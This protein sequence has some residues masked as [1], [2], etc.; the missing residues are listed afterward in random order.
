MA[1]FGII[2]VAL[3]RFNMSSSSSGYSDF[4]TDYDLQDLIGVGSFGR[5]YQAFCKTN[6]REC[7]V[8]AICKKPSRTQGA[9][10]IAKIYAEVAVHLK[11]RNEHILQLYNVIEDGENVYLILE[12]CQGGSLS[13][14]LKQKLTPTKLTT[15]QLRRT[16]SETNLKGRRTLFPSPPSTPEHGE[17]K[18][19]ASAF[20]HDQIRCILVQVLNGLNYLHRNKIIHRD[21][22][23]NNLLLKTKFT[24]DVQEIVI[25]IADFG[26]ALD[27]S[28]TNG[29]PFTKGHV[30]NP[31]TTSFAGGTI[32][33]T[34]GFISPE[35]WTQAQPISPASDL[36]GVGSILYS[37][38]TGFTPRGDIDLSDMSPWPADLISN[39]LDPNPQNRLSIDAV[40]SHPYIVGPLSTKRL[41]PIK[42]ESK[43]LIFSIDEDSN[44]IVD[45]GKSKG[46]I[47]INRN[48]N[49][50]VFMN[51]KSM[52]SFSFDGLP[53][54]HW[55]KYL[56]AHRFVKMVKDKTP[57]VILY[58]DSSFK[59]S[60]IDFKGNR[61][62]I[63]KCTL[64][65]SGQF[66]AA[67]QDKL[68][69]EVKKVIFTARLE[70]D[71]CVLYA[72]LK[73]LKEHCLQV[74]TQLDALVNKTGV[75]C[76]PMTMG[77]RSGQKTKSDQKFNSP[78][79][80]YSTMHSTRTNSSSYIRSLYVQ[81]V[82]TITQVSSRIILNSSIILLILLVPSCPIVR[83][84]LFSLMVHRCQCP[85]T[86]VYSMHIKGKSK[87]KL[88]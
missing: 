22:N 57:K 28:Q 61:N 19:T 56:Y 77:R 37:L 74:E 83:L 18:L 55:K 45:F 30:I 11:L 26:L 17:A 13:Q 41:L 16:S 47:K 36:F 42:K 58:C 31:Y 10:N 75:E 35:V 76:F 64:M 6:N 78:D 29:E 51:N 48:G 32:C 43:K 5:V 15:P 21:L 46:S 2:N 24:E 84:K 66:E 39:L 88:T 67:V 71:N 1:Q 50:V 73:D 54:Q 49:E 8:K 63:V 53:Q 85:R 80:G 68:S 79:V 81:G 62:T 59:V 23:L 14:L 4:I 87:G 34:P 44:V 40:L 82:G 86:R 52:T 65:E 38:L 7:A 60:S 27:L 70:N 12:L 72:Q 33:G 9:P 3:I 25:K 20:S 69:K